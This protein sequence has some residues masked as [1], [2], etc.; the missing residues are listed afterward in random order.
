MAG[1]RAVGMRAIWR[2]DPSVSQRVEADAVIEELWD[3]LT[4]LGLVNMGRPT[5]NRSD[6]GY[7]AK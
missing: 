2:R 3:L 5:P 4:L 6:A 7:A 1:A